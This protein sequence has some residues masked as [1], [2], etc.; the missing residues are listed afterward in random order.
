MS[1]QAKKGLYRLIGLVFLICLVKWAYAEP[2]CKAAATTFMGRDNGQTVYY[3]C[4]DNKEVADLLGYNEA[5]FDLTDYN[6][7][8][9]KAPKRDS[10]VNLYVVMININD[11]FVVCYRAEEYDFF[12]YSWDFEEEDF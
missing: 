10:N 7:V 11:T 3:I 4:Q 12:F 8:V 2:C 9:R 6:M 1:P 5:D